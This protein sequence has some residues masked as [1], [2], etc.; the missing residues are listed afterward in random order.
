ME[1][2]TAD[3]ITFLEEV[4]DHQ[5]R[6]F[7]R[8]QLLPRR[9][10]GFRDGH[11]PINRTVPILISKLKR[12]QELTNPDSP[13]WE[14]FKNAW[15]CWVGSHTELNDI[16][17]EFDNSADFDEND[18]CIAPPNSELD[19]QCFHI[20]LEA[21]HNNQIDQETIRHFYKYGHF[22][23]DEQIEELIDKALPHEEI[24]RRRRLAEL[25]DQ[26]DNLRHEIDELRTQISELN[27]SNELQP[28]IRFANFRNS[29]IF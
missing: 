22:N 6:T 2:D 20:L 11:A 14:L 17:V 8:N 13:I 10:P 16:L 28:N 5:G 9:V 26:V 18:K 3:F 29:A 7:I 25:P 1:R 24:E 12:K 4:T 21:N 15:M 23:K 27:P 19:I